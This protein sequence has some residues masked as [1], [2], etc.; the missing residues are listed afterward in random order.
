MLQQFKL[1]LSTNNTDLSKLQQKFLKYAH[2]DD[3]SSSSSSSWNLSILCQDVGFRKPPSDKMANVTI[4][5]IA[6]R[7]EN[8]IKPNRPRCRLPAEQITFS[9]SVTSLP[10][11]ALLNPIQT[12]GKIQTG[13]PS[14]FYASSSILLSLSILIPYIFHLFIYPALAPFFISTLTPPS[15]GLTRQPAPELS[16]GG[17][18]TQVFFHKCVS[19]CVCVRARTVNDCVRQ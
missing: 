17:A 5:T 8:A 16:A 4:L 13:H 6:N 3:S 14:V 9:G 18:T 12:V 15:I 2:H 1:I 11:D 7:G 19:V 10:D